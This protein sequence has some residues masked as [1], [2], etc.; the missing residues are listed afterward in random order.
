MCNVG[1]TLNGAD[2]PVIQ[3]RT[4]ENGDI[5]PDQNSVPL[6]VLNHPIGN[7]HEIDFAAYDD[8]TPTVP[9]PVDG[10]DAV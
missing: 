10:P 8:P 2:V 5:I 4:L 3:S 9:P 7:R 1:Y 6:A